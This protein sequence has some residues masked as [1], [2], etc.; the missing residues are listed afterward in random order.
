MLYAI[1]WMAPLVKA[2]HMATRPAASPALAALVDEAFSETPGNPLRTTQAFVVAQHGEIVLERY[3]P[4]FDASSTFISWSMAKSMAA[5][6]VGILV[7]DGVLNLDAPAPVAAWHGSDDP[8][9]AITLRHL[10]QM[11]SGLSWIED[12]VDDRA[13]DVIDMLASSDMAA[14][15]INKS[16]ADTPGESWLYSSGTTNIIAKIIGDTLG[17]GRAVEAALQDRLFG[18]VGMSSAT[19][20]FDASG[21]WVASSF[22]Y[23]TARDF[24][25]FGE[26]M[27]NDGVANGV[28]VLPEGW[29]ELSTRAHVIDPD[30]GQG[31]GLQWWTVDQPPRS[32]SANGYEGQ[33]IEVVPE[34]G[35]SFVRLGK[36]DAA[37][38]DHLRSFY[39][40]IATSFG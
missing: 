12:Y 8:R 5:A 18:P 26:L 3:A 4:G 40:S 16:L 29:V 32:F 21:T 28:R 23:A 37:F 22:V 15:A 20:K 1:S 9:R 31:Y 13:S 24:L 35:V 36:T 11:R 2:I 17:G 25:A 27:R 6:L 30:S 7:N 33:R 39:R 10:L 38:A 34:H 14:L 19:P